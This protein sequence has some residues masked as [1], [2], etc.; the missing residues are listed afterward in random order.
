VEETGLYGA[1]GQSDFNFIWGLSLDRSWRRLRFLPSF[2]WNIHRS[3]QNHLLFKSLTDTSPSF[4][5]EYYDFSEIELGIPVALSMSKSWTAGLGFDLRHRAYGSRTARDSANAIMEGRDQKNAMFVTTLSLFK[6][7]KALSS[8]S[9]T[10]AY[11]YAL[12]NN[13]YER[14]MPYNY[15]GSNLSL[16]YQLEY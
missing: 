9:L 11:V 14:Y 5:A 1:R 4:Q 7:M 10:Y 3:N 15:W 8:W 2:R 6:K 16:G 12:S 13:K